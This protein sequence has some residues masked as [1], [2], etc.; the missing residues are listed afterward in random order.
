MA[1]LIVFIAVYS[2]FES[3]DFI[4]E[5]TIL[6]GTMSF[7][8]CVVLSVCVAIGTQIPVFI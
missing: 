4:D 5:V 3:V 1:L 8:G 7:W 2:Q 6:F